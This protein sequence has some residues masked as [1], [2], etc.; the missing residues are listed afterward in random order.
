M[1]NTPEQIS[2]NELQELENALS[3][4]INHDK[5]IPLHFAGLIDDLIEHHNATKGMQ[6]NYIKALEL[7][8]AADCPQCKD[9]QGAYY[10]NHGEVCQCQWCY[11]VSCLPFPT[12][13]HKDKPNE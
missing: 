10:G 5:P 8:K 1:T 12:T 7:L 4:G 11:E 3:E 2:A 6:D 13:P 9:K